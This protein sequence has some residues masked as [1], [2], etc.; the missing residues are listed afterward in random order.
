MTMTTF[1]R[2]RNHDLLERLGHWIHVV[3]MLLL[4]FSGLQIHFVSFAVF[5]SLN[6]ARY[7]HFVTMYVFFFIGV[8][9]AY[10][11]FAAGKWR[12]AGPL[13]VNLKGLGATVKYYLFITDERPTYRKYNP[14]QIITYFLLFAVSASMAVVGFALYWPVALGSVVRFFGGP[15]TLRQIHYLLSW[16]FI[17]FTAFHLYLVLTQEPLYMLKSMVTGS[18]W[19]KATRSRQPTSQAS[20][21]ESKTAVPPA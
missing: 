12:V 6:N 14:L 9:H 3:N 5:G 16:V 13:P 20:A 1:Q 19:R 10:R 18:Y 15:M 2:V 7:V 17:C 8:F 4:I 21:G 11:F